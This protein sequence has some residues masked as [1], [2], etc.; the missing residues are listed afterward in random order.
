MPENNISALNIESNTDHTRSDDLH[1]VQRYI[2]DD[3]KNTWAVLWRWLE[4]TTRKAYLLLATATAIVAMFFTLQPS[5][6]YPLML[7]PPVFVIL[8]ALPCAVPALLPIRGKWDG[9]RWS[10]HS[11]LPYDEVL[12]QS[13]QMME[14]NIDE[15]WNAY[16][17][18]RN[19]LRR[20]RK[21][22]SG[23]I[24]TGIFSYIAISVIQSQ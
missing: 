13:G 8:G 11:E 24:A 12:E 2:C 10:E 5:D 17:R 14:N 23:G 1:E 7:I 18:S 9:L 16:T 6:T 21:F 15:L 20:G 22:W 3:M 19:W 4:A